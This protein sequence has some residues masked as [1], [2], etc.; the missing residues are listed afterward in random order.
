VL[1]LAM[2]LSAALTGST[3]PPPMLFIVLTFV[4][5]GLAFTCAGRG[6]RFF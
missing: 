5:I 3:L 2:L 1:V 6:Y 4:F